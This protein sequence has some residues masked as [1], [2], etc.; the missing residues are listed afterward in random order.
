MPGAR[1]TRA[2]NVGL[3][4]D[5]L[6]ELVEQHALVRARGCWRSRRW[7]RRAGS[8]R[9]APRAWQRVDERDRAA[10]RRA[11]RLAAP[12]GRHRRARR[13]VGGARRSAAAKPLPVSRAC[14]SSAIPNGRSA[15]RCATSAACASTASCSGW[16]RR[17]SF[18]RACGETALSAFVDRRHVDAGDRDRRARPDAR[19]EAAGADQRQPRQHLGELAELLVAVGLARPLLA[20]Q[21]RRPR[22]RRARRAARRARAAATISA[23]GAAPPN[24]PLCLAPAERRDLDRDH[25]HAAQRDGQRRHAGPHAAHVGD[26]HRVGS[27][28]PRD[29][30]GG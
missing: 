30:A 27:G 3:G 13:L 20:P 22:R 18:A 25:R 24:W 9:P 8:R 16:T 17:L 19:A 1:R 12:G 28:T 21:A 5:R 29:A 14:T 15:S 6:L 2:K 7:R 10:A 11:D 23:S 4:G 26:H